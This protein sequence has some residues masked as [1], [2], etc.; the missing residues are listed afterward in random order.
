MI[1]RMVP[2]ISPALSPSLSTI[3]D[4][5]TIMTGPAAISYTGNFDDS[6]VEG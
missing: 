2:M 6:L 3:R 4:V 5:R 1:A